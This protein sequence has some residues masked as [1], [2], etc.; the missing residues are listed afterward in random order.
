MCVV[1]A[2]KPLCLSCR[3]ERV[4]GNQLTADTTARWHD[5]PISAEYLDIVG[6][7]V[8]VLARG[9]ISVPENFT[10]RGFLQLI[11]VHFFLPAAAK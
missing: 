9:V 4:E 5:M 11:S 3:L 8:L 6:P 10:F 7:E 1:S 2:Q